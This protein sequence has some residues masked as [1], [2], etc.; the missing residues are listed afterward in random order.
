MK[1]V[2]LPTA[3]QDIA[4]FRQYYEN[5][6][7]DGRIRAITQLKSIEVHLLANP[8]LGSA[9]KSYP[10]VRE[11]HIARTP[12]S[13]FYRVT[14]KQIEVLRLWDERQDKNT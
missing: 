6:F 13:V 7:P 4:W 12:Y 10:E 9:S 11:L 3:A 14:Q 5:V 1:L 2:Y 8:H